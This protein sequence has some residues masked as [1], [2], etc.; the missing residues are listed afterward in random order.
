MKIGYKHY[1]EDDKIAIVPDIS[2][3]NKYYQV[4]Y[5]PK[6]VEA[7]IEY[8]NKNKE[9]MKYKIIYER[10]TK[11]GRKG[12]VKEQG[13]KLENVCYRIKIK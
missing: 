11:N 1:Y 7:I 9:D 8:L 5:K 4:Y 3:G 6:A 10:S 12:E 2:K 13:Y